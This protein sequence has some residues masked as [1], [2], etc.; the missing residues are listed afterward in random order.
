MIVATKLGEINN[1]R[2]MYNSKPQYSKLN[3]IHQFK[4]PT[5]NNSTDREIKTEA[6]THY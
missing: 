4:I 2:I 6:L 1:K 5:I 3:F